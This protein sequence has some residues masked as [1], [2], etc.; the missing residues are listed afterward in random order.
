ML[1][2]NDPVISGMFCVLLLMSTCCAIRTTLCNANVRG[3]LEPPR[4]HLSGIQSSSA[5]HYGLTELRASGS[6][7]R[8][9][10]DNLLGTYSSGLRGSTRIILLRVELVAISWE[11]RY[12]SRY[13][14]FLSLSLSRSY[15]EL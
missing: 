14:N 9:S 8:L 4:D 6:G 11:Y 1:I 5:R 7:A 15:I 12:L 10:R 13:S 3:A 2:I